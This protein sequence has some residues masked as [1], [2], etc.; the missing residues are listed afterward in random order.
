MYQVKAAFLYNFVTFTTWPA[1]ALA[2][3]TDPLRI[4]VF[5]NDEL[6]AEVDATVRGETIDGHPIVVDRVAAPDEA[7]RCHVLF[8]PR[9]ES[10]HEAGLLDAVKQS[11]VLTIGES[12][13]FLRDGGIVNF[14]IENGRVR[15]D[16]NQRDARDHGA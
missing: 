10:F 1:A 3:P 14:V 13:Q 2:T 8:V 5:K 12:D 11:P 6:A 15:F 16:V 7:A 4:C 9:T